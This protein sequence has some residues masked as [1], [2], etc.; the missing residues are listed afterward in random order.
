MALQLRDGPLF[1]LGAH[2]PPVMA[3]KMKILFQQAKISTADV[4]TARDV[5][6]RKTH[7]LTFMGFVDLHAMYLKCFVLA[8]KIQVW[9][10]VC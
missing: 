8:H 5:R 2:L 3:Q 7:H 1:P 10:Y 9:I 6:N 4:H